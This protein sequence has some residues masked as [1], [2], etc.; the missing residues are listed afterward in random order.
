MREGRHNVP[1]I[2]TEKGIRKLTSEEC[3]AF[4]GFLLKGKKRFRFPFTIARGKKYKQAG[5][6]VTVPLVKRIAEKLIEFI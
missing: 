3:L 2:Y 5:N 6:S 4:Q 1:I